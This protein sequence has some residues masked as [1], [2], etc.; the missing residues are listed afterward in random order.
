MPRILIAE[1]EPRIV[2]FLEKGLQQQGY[3]TD[4]AYDGETAL[5]KASTEV[6]DLMLLDLGLPKLEGW[7]VLQQIRQ[8]GNSMLV[9]IVTAQSGIGDY[10]QSLLKGAND[11]IDKPFRFSRLLNRIKHHLTQS[12]DPTD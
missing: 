9:I 3:E 7:T 1:D 4:V 8:Q 11:Y 12:S 6:Y 2:A 10:Q 5:K